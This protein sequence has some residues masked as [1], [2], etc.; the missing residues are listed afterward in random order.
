MTASGATTRSQIRGA[1]GTIFGT[2]E[3]PADELR[4]LATEPGVNFVFNIAD[5]LA[6]A[7]VTV[8]DPDNAAVTPESIVVYSIRSDGFVTLASKGAITEGG[9]DTAADILA[10]A[11]VFSAVTGIGTAGN[12]IETETSFI[13]A[14]TNTGGINL[15]NYGSLQIGNISS[16]VE[17]LD[18]FNSGDLK[19]TTTG[20]FL[21]ND[22][23]GPEVVHGGDISGNVTLSAIGPDSDM[24]ATVDLPVVSAAGGGITLTA[25]RD[26]YLGTAAANFNNDV[27]AAGA[28]TINAGRDFVLDG[29]S[30]LLTSAFGAVPGG[31]ITIIAGRNIGLLDTSGGLQSIRAFNGNLVL[32]TGPGGTYT[33]DVEMN[34]VTSTGDI[35]I[36][37]D[38]AAINDGGIVAGYASGIGQVTIRPVSPGRAID[39]GNPLDPASAL[40]LSNAELG[41]IGAPSLA[42]G[43]MNSGP[44]S[45][46]AALAFSFV[47]D[48]IIRSATEILVD[49]TFFVQRNLTLRAGDDVFVTAAGGITSATGGLSVFVDD[50]Q[51]DAGTG[52]NASLFG[53][54]LVNTTVVLNGNLDA[55]VLNGAASNDMLMGNGGNDIL[56]GN[57]GND[58]L[59]GGL[60][61]DTTNGGL[62]DD[63]HFIDSAADVVIE[64][65]GEGTDTVQSSISFGLR[66]RCR[67]P[68]SDR[69]R[70][71]QR[72]RQ[73]PR[74]HDLRQ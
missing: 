42:I 67:E 43:D 29:T 74:Q 47:N 11:I 2:F 30:D 56:V 27:L 45:V 70:R 64:A 59:N 16:S 63:T 1:D 28:I 7:V 46:N 49:A 53:G 4:F 6:T 24:F 36:N 65:A 71:H 37:A 33:Q 23:T 55:D 25:G 32:T 5:F 66:R 10:N 39:L 21:F 20:F 58:Q 48:V 69:Y 44:V 51:D 50:A 35:T 15:S 38:Q 34:A 73:R 62:G 13:E 14:E 12:A 22:T 26:L 17:G 19:V 31:H 54:I 3:H 40:A 61:A 9:S 18:V 52:G 68:D 41:R 57:G 72:H 8:G 60:G